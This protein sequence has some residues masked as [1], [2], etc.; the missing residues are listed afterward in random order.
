MTSAPSLANQ[1]REERLNIQKRPVDEGEVTVRKEVCTEHK[2]V[3]VPVTREE[4]VIERHPGHGQRASSETLGEGKEIRVLVRSEEV[5]IQKET[6]VAEEV[7][8]GKRRVQETERVDENLRKEEIRV[9][10]RGDVDVKDTK[11]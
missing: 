11:R 3:D 5:D 8:V 2:T 6:A 7:T 1:A 9:E 10:K 4:I